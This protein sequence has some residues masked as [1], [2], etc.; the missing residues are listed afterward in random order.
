MMEKPQTSNTQASGSPE[1]LPVID[2]YLQLES[3]AIE[4]GIDISDQVKRA[5]SLF[6]TDEPYNDLAPHTNDR[7]HQFLNLG[8][9]AI[10]H[11]RTQEDPR[12]VT[13]GC[14]E[15]FLANNQQQK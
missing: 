9:R 5:H 13:I 7:W 11:A 6:A 1:Q 12:S 3:S 14:L 8:V 10:E 2:A 4:L 15:Y